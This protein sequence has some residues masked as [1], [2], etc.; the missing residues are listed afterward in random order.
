MQPTDPFNDRYADLLDG[1]DD[2]VDRI[3][4][5]GYSR[6][7][8]SSGGFRTWWRQLFGDD[9]NLD[10]AH[11]IRFAGRFAR[12]PKSTNHHERADRSQRTRTVFLGDRRG[13]SDSEK[14]KRRSRPKRPA[15]LGWRSQPR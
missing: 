2:C 7:I 6:F 4:L 3:V 10:N 5:N 8:Q 12:R 15:P 14:N 9:D 13:R 1:A 11:L